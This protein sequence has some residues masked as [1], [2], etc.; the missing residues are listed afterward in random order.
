MPKKRYLLWVYMKEV[1]FY[2]DSTEV[3]FNSLEYFVKYSFF[4]L[5]KFTLVCHRNK[6]KDEARFVLDKYC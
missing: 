1:D 5:E 4:V 3:I 6:L 2:Y